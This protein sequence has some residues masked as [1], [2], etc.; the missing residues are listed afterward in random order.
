LE[1]PALDTREAPAG[2]HVFHSF[3]G[4]PRQQ[5]LPWL[6]V[7]CSAAAP[8]PDVPNRAVIRPEFRSGHESFFGSYGFVIARVDGGQR[9]VITALHVLDEVAKFRGIDCSISNAAYTGFELPKQ[10]TGIQLYDPFAPKWM[11]AELG[12]AADMLPLPNAGINAVEPYSQRDIAAFRVA[13]AAPLQ[14]LQ[15]AQSIPAVG[16][17]IWLAAKLRPDA[18]ERTAQAIVV[19]MTPETFVFRFASPMT[20]PTHTSGAPLLNRAGEVVGINVGGGI[21]D[22]HK[23]GHG[24]HV[25]SI[26][27]HLG[28]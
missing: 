7:P 19:E 13:S 10:I 16:E 18:V 21:F 8:A 26:R 23:L 28:W 20:S 9:L 22:G 12:T 11:L 14:P 6:A 1:H 24:V 4:S 25:A 5:I 2:Q 27:H 15:L 3:E 17:P